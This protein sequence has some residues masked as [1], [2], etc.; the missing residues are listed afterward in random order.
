[1]RDDQYFHIMRFKK[2]KFIMMN[3]GVNWIKEIT[4]R[5]ELIV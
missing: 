5:E 1:L 4:P 2:I 3:N